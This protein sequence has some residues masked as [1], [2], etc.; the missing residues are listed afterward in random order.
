MNTLGGPSGPPAG[1]LSG[2]YRSRRSPTEKSPL[3]VASW[4]HQCAVT[5]AAYFNCHASAASRR[6]PWAI[7]HL[8]GE[9]VGGGQ[10]MGARQRF[11]PLQGIVFATFLKEGRPKRSIRQLGR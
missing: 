8:F 10:N 5:Q 3:V 6:F 9:H 1:R 4:R 2:S 11:C 7:E